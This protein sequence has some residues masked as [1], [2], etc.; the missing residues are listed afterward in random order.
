MPDEQ[1]QQIIKEFTQKI[2]EMTDSIKEQAAIT[3]VKQIYKNIEIDTDK[4][5]NNYILLS[6]MQMLGVALIS[7]I[8]AVLIMLLCNTSFASLRG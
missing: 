6:G 8:S 5:Q 4:I 7:M 3:T 2:D 1:K